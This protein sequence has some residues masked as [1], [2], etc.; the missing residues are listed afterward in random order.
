MV[1]MAQA[2]Q[3][4]TDALVVVAGVPGAGKTTLIRRAVDR[5]VAKVVDKEDVRDAA[6]RSPSLPNVRHYVQLVRALR[7]PRPVILH[8]RGTSRAVRRLILTLAATARRPAHL[9]LLDVDHQAAEAGQRDRGRMVGRGPMQRHVAR[10]RRLV[11]RP[12]RLRREGW[13]SV[14]V[15]SRAEA[16][17][18]LALDFRPAVAPAGAA[19]QPT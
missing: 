11:D 4:P 7:R 9:I 3:F 6:G 17:G 15:L 18:V 1:P 10:W 12:Q 5:D 19:P 13:A 16:A 14:T 8:T 2:L